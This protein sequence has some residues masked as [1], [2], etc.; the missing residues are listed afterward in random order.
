M[1]GILKRD[2]FIFFFCLHEEEKQIPYFHCRVCVALHL[3]DW[4]IES[5]EVSM[6]SC[7]SVRNSAL[8]GPF[9]LVSNQPIA[10]EQM[11]AIKCGQTDQ[12]ENAKIGEGS[13]VK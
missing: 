4:R 7:V 1:C 5:V 9:V 12:Q 13:E 8:I 10:E 11:K 3:D 2:F 6:H